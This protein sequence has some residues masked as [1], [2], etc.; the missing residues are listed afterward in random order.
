VSVSWRVV[1]FGLGDR[2]RE[3]RG[4]PLGDRLGRLNLYGSAQG[5]F[6]NIS[7]SNQLC[8]KPLVSARVR[9][10]NNGMESTS[11]HKGRKAITVGLALLAVIAGGAAFASSGPGSGGTLPISPPGF[12]KVAEFGQNG[13]DYVT[14]GASQ[15]KG[16][17][18]GAQGS[19]CSSVNTTSSSNSLS[20]PASAS[21]VKAYLYW[22]GLE[23]HGGRGYPTVQ[24]LSKTVSFTPAGKSTRT[25]TANRRM[26]AGGTYNGGPIQYAG[27][28]A[29]VTSEIGTM[30]GTYSVG[31][32]GGIP[33]LCAYMGEN[34]RAWQ[35]VLVYD[36]PSA[37]Y[38][39][40][41][42]YDGLEYLVNTTRSFGISGYVAPS[43]R[44]SSLTAFVAQG[45]STLAGEYANTSDSSFPN[46][47]TNY[48]DETVNGSASTASGQAVDIDTLSGNLTPGSTS[49]TVDVGTNQDVIVPMTFVLRM[50]SLP[51]APPTTT[52]TVPATTTTTAPATTTTVPATTT[53][54]PPTTT[55]VPTT[56]VPPTTVAPTTT[57]TLP[58]VV[59]P[60]TVAPTTTTTL[61]A[62]VAPTTVAPTTTT[63]LPPLGPPT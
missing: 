55:T 33:G 5:A 37:L 38:S 41:Y 60:T 63:T 39:K 9:S 62:F 34:A 29:D 19:N 54:V 7:L 15:V 32:S 58:A 4:S 16:D 51:V 17:G 42:V 22:V 2:E 49:M 45:D 10:D 61:P 30:S 1:G 8:A 14:T 13:I 46:F 3:L 50:S 23:Q 52:T 36:M 43:G 21:K 53:T 11:S 40:L 18:G 12:T 27:Y 26:V 47:P 6:P 31:I 57:T 59:A 35:L 44:P 56:T 24:T 25:V 20:V 28:V 48:A